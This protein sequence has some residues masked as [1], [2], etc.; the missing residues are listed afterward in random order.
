MRLKATEEAIAVSAEETPEYPPSLLSSLEQ[1]LLAILSVRESA[2]PDTFG[3]DSTDRSI[4]SSL[5]S[6]FE[7]YFKM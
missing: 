7:T 1:I 4:F 5:G 2:G 3:S 6:R